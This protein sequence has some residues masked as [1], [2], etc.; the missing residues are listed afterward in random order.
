[1]LSILT[2]ADFFTNPQARA[3]MLTPAFDEAYS[4][5]VLRGICAHYGVSVPT[6]GGNAPTPSKPS[7]PKSDDV[8]KSLLRVLA[9]DLWVYDKPDW[10]ARAFT[11]KKGE[12]FTVSRELTINGSKMYQLISGLYITANSKYVEFDGVVASTPTKKTDQQLA[13]EVRAGLHGNGDARK[14]SLGS[15]YDAVQA[16]INGSAT[17]APSKLAVR[18]GEGIVSYMKRAGMDS[19][20]ANRKRLAQQHGISNYRGTA[21]QNSRLLTLISR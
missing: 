14:K 5:A 17:K 8:G 10:S 13:N 1:M 9:E 3:W 7:E 20:M 16:I 6:T 15:R 12:A 4:N 11:V 19:S 18:A 21:A 2:E